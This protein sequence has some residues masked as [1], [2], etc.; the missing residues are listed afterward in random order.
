MP[1][2]SLLTLDYVQVKKLALQTLDDVKY[3]SVF[4]LLSFKSMLD[5]DFWESTRHLPL[6]VFPLTQGQDFSSQV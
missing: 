2:D 1:T 5:A 6:Q 3:Q 4:S